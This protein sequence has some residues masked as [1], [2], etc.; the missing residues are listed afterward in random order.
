MGSCCQ[1]LI[2]SGL[3]LVQG[4]DSMRRRRMGSFSCWT[5]LCIVRA[6]PPP[7]LSL[8]RAIIQKLFEALKDT[9]T[10]IDLDSH[11]VLSCLHGTWV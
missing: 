9:C 4:T 5:D 2:S 1:T 8:C 7:L 11:E 6:P 10:D 3:L